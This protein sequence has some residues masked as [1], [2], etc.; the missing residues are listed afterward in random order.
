MVL[1]WRFHPWFN[2]KHGF[3]IHS[4][5]TGSAVRLP[6]PAIDKPNIY[7]FGTP[8][9]DIYRDLYNKDPQ[10]YTQNGLLQMLDR[11][12][13][14]KRAPEQWQTS[15][16]VY[17]VIFTC[18]ER[19]FDA[20]CDELLNRGSQLNIPVHVINLE[21]KDNH[22]EAEVGGKLFLQLASMH[23]PLL[24]VQKERRVVLSTPQTKT[25]FG[26][27]VD[28][29]PVVD[30]RTITN[31]SYP[32]ATT[33][34]LS[35]TRTD[36]P[37]RAALHRAPTMA[38]FTAESQTPL[39][40]F[41]DEKQANPWFRWR[42]SVL[43][44]VLPHI[45][46][47]TVYTAIV[48]IVDQTT[49]FHLAISKD[50]IPILTI[51]LGLLMAFRTNLSYDR[52]WEG[53]KL[54]T[55]LISQ[56]R[57]AARL[58]HSS[59]ATEDALTTPQAKLDHAQKIAAMKLLVGFAI[60]VKHHLRGEHG[61]G[62]EDFQG[63]LPMIPVKKGFSTSRRSNIEAANS[64]EYASHD[65]EAHGEVEEDNHRSNYSCG[66]TNVP[67]TISHNL[68][69]LI[70]GKMAKG[71]MSAVVGGASLSAITSL[72]DVVTNLDRILTT[73][74]PLAYHLHLK[75]I[76]FLYILL[77][78][79]QLVSTLGW[80]T[81]P[82][83]ALASFLLVGIEQIGLEIENPFGYDANDLPLDLYC[84]NLHREIDQLIEEPNI[85]Y[86]SGWDFEGFLNKN[87]SQKKKG[88][89]LGFGGRS[90]QEQVASVAQV[91]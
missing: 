86:E 24:G 62:Y 7:N 78:P 3:Q 89:F 18:E 40:I 61:V 83:V 57:A 81:I 10:L 1:I 43:P 42:G 44:A 79:Y 84:N 55:T 30:T 91:Q 27:V 14:T 29:A 59:L 36:N 52:F 47:F 34:L 17:D 48:V 15:R 68:T 53:R 5:G 20:V 32:T 8:Y 33:P 65:V 16:Q 46:G 80:I 37:G 50:L 54:W 51:V 82:T 26:T 70:T 90:N 64:L 49:G 58:L 88:G 56:V 21:I 4:Y 2:S 19:C 73:K 74:I 67:I 13:R 11:N 69:S 41:I 6:G 9:D 12:R 72:V 22:Q 76:L 77:L 66:C 63:L 39:P 75:H 45:I 28:R 85:D 23:P 71:T 87:L 35:P 38:A 31:M 60:A 25:S